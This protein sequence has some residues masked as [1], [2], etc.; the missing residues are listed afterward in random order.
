MKSEVEQARFDEWSSLSSYCQWLHN[1]NILSIKTLIDSSKHK[2]SC[3][4]SVYHLSQY[5]L[6]V[7]LHIAGGVTVDV[8]YWIC[9]SGDSTSGFLLHVFVK[10]AAKLLRYVARLGEKDGARQSQ[11]HIYKFN[12]KF[13]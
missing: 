4:P 8:G 11:Y 12:G 1:L 2:G 7:F 13:K 6:L 9:Y 5:I 10:G 3:L